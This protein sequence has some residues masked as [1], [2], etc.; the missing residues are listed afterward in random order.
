MVDKLDERLLGKSLDTID[1]ISLEIQDMS[2]FNDLVRIK[3]QELELKQKKNL[4]LFII[5]GLIIASLTTVLL[6]KGT[7]IFIIIQILFTFVPALTIFVSR[8]LK[9]LRGRVNG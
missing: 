6:Y 1:E 7:E 9:M 5:I 2:F 8:I 4:Y 3:K